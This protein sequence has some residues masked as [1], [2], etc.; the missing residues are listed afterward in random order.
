[1]AKK[2][3][4][5]PQSLANLRPPWKE[6]DPSP[7]PGG[8]LKKRPITDEYFQILGEP[9]PEILRLQIN[10]MFGEELL[11]PGTTWARAG[12]FRRA[13]DSLMEGGYLAS[14]EMR[15]AIEGKAPLRSE[16]TGPERKEVTLRVV[17]GNR[18]N[19][20]SGG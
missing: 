13:L 3:M 8:R 16:I 15:E 18:L 10:Q 17:Y 5:P 1:M 2:Y 11:R 9:L 7:N 6:G 20:S 14:K 12:A 19:P 4:P